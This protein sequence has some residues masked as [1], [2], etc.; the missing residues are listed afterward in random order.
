MVEK[1]V[2]YR[3]RESR[4]KSYDRGYESRRDRFYTSG[5][6]RENMS[7]ERVCCCPV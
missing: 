6:W 4:R 5:P 2:V 3:D 1:E 7:V